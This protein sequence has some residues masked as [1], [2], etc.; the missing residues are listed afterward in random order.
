MKV[1]FAGTPD[2]A[3][4]ALNA[5]VDAG[6]DVPL[7]L[8][9][10]DRPKGRGMQLQ[11]SP[12]KLAALAHG[13]RV[14]QPEKLRG[15]DEALQ[16]LRDVQADVMVVAAYGLILPQDVLDTPQHGC[17]N[18]H[19]SLLPRWRGAAPIQRA[20]E[21]GDTETG[22]CIMQMDAGL[23]T[24]AIVSEH[25][26]I[27]KNTD[28]ANEVHDELMKLGAAAIV[29]DLQRLQ[30]SGSLK[31]V[32]QPENGITY[33]QK[34][35]KDEA[36]INWQESAEIVAR[37]IRAFNPVPCAWTLWQGKPMKIWT[38]HPVAQNGTAGTV[39]AAN[40]N[41]IIVACGDGAICIS[42]LQA[43]GG[44][45]LNSKDFLAGRDVAVG[46]FFA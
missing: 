3:A 8:T 30:V 24:G 46:E 38:A 25:R 42:E 32:P 16:I 34:L 33:A 6:F 10:P 12:V 17:L 22:V 18:I 5:I 14:E 37:K 28:T 35:S 41:S 29:A 43:A 19:A 27:I 23:D 1:I 36:Q 4:A 39:L 11:A 40:A 31:S 26:Y 20:I 9:Q 44:K 2:F 21:A 7:V 13:L 45:R 15:N